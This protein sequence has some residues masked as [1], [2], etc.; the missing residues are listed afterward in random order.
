MRPESIDTLEESTDSSFSDIGHS[1]VISDK[2]HEARETKAKMNYWD[3][4]KTES[5]CT[6]RELTNKTK[7]QPTELEK[8]FSNYR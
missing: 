8:V 7:Q 3:Y 1:N 5:F 2:S 6:A 4:I